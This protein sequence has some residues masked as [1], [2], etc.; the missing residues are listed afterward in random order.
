[1][2]LTDE[3]QFEIDTYGQ[4]LTGG[5]T[6]LDL[7]RLA[8]IHFLKKKMRPR[9]AAAIG[10]TPDNLTDAIRALILGDAI[11]LGMVTDAA[12]VEAYKT[13]IAGLIE[14]YGG[15]EAILSVLSG[16]SAAIGQYVVA[17]YFAAKTE[18]MACDDIDAIREIDLP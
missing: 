4:L 1:M 18:I 17:G 10:D 8:R 11:A 9:L 7:A 5:E 2:S 16:S 12:V 13:Y 3:K 6:E 15:P 14:G